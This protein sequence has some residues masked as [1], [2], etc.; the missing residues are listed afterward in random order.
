MLKAVEMDDFKC[1]EALDLPCSALTVLTGYNAAGKSTALQALLL[2]SQALR[3]AANE[4]QLPLNGELVSLGSEGDVLRFGASN[5]SFSLGVRTPDESIKWTFGS[6]K[7]KS[8]RG[9]VPLRALEYLKNGHD[10]T[11]RGKRSSKRIWPVSEGE[12]SSLASAVQNIVFISADRALQL[13]TFPVPRMPF[14]PEG[15]VG[16]TGEYAAYWYLE[17]ADEEVEEVRRHPSESG[18]TVRTQVDAWL[19]EL[20][21]GT[22]RALSRAFGSA[23]ASSRAF[24]FPPASLFPPP[25]SLFPGTRV[26]ADRLTPDAP[27]RLTFSLSKSS[28]R[29]RPANVGFGLSYAFPMLVALLTRAR[30]SIIV[31]DSAEAHLHPRAQSAVGR[32]L[33]QMAGAGLQ[34]FIETHSDHLVNGVRLAVRDGLVKPDDVALHF[35]GQGGNVGQVTTLAL[36]RNG[37]VSDWPEGFFDQA[38]NDLAILSGWK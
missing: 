22:S 26:S 20:F 14:H 9:L 12:E 28:P 38:E 19:S 35:F 21:P 24:S 34:I 27:I 7:E 30:G 33:G 6:R 16:A 11:L 29:A 25:A 10:S 15:D 4:S 17:C 18:Q 31:V 36:D 2:M 13:D 23:P 3:I 32:L 37:A 8:A 5:P 1:F